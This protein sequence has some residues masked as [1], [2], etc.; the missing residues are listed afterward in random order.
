MKHAT[1]TCILILVLATASFAQADSASIAP[2]IRAAADSMLMAFKQKDYRTFARFNNE[3]LVESLGGE[4]NFA[5][6]LDKQI[7]SLEELQFTEIRTGRIIRVMPYQNT[8]QCIVEQQSQVRIPEQVMSTI[9]HLV[10]LSTDGGYTWHFADANQGTVEQF[11]TI[12][13]ELNPAMPIPKKKLA[14]A[15]TLDQLLADYQTSYLP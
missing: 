1:I 8:W 12:M 3:K 5:A 11:R 13:P 9:S 15:K 14:I 4:E 10:G 6:F 2:R 7:K